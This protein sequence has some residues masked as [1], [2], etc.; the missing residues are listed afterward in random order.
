VDGLKLHPLHVV[1]HTVLA[2][3]WRRGEYRPLGREEYIR[4]ACDLIERTPEHIVYHR[5]T[6]TASKDILL[7]PEWCS[8]KWNVLNGIE[9][10]L[11]RRGHRQGCLAGTPWIEGSQ[12]KILASAHCDVAPNTRNLLPTE[13]GTKFLERRPESPVSAYPTIPVIR[14]SCAASASTALAEVTKEEIL[15]A[16]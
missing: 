7:A 10:E 9:L 4:H 6:G 8:Q 16:A 3:Q 2:N 15:N 11:K 1:K 12:E 14:A 13:A 5:V